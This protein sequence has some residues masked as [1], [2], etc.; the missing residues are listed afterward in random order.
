V[1]NKISDYKKYK[2]LASVFESNKDILALMNQNKNF[3]FVGLTTCD[4]L[5][6][7]KMNDLFQE[8]KEETKKIKKEIHENLNQENDNRMENMQAMIIDRGFDINKTVSQM[9]FNQKR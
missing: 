6:A 1:V 3:R 2:E 4:F 8:E 9:S 7:I 5:N